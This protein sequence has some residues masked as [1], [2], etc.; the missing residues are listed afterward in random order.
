MSHLGLGLQPTHNAI[1]PFLNRIWHDGIPAPQITCDLQHPALGTNLKF[2]V[3]T[4]TLFFADLEPELQRRQHYLPRRLF[5]RPF[6]HHFI[7]RLLWR[8]HR[9]QVYIDLAPRGCMEVCL[10]P[11]RVFTPQ[12]ARNAPFLCIRVCE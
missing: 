9:E 12:F 6:L 2:Y 7:P 8:S 3:C 10:G 4:S 11:C 1:H 5:R